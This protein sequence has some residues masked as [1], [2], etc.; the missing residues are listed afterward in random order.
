MGVGRL[1]L[2]EEGLVSTENCTGSSFGN[3][4]AAFA[5][6][7]HHVVGQEGWQVIREEHRSC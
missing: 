2:M 5:A 3:Q 6:Q 4:R 1:P 7:G